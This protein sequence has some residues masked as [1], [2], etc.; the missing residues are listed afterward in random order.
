[1]L[2]TD[3]AQAHDF[4]PAC[5][6]A[7]AAP[8][9]CHGFSIAPLAATAL[10][11]TALTACAWQSTIYAPAGVSDRGYSERQIEGDRFRILD[12][13]RLS[14]APYAY[15]CC[16]PFKGRGAFVPQR[17]VFSAWVRCCQKKNGL[18][19]LARNRSVLRCVISSDT[20]KLRRRPILH[21]QPFSTSNVISTA[22]KISRRTDPPPW[23]N[24]VNLQ[25]ELGSNTVFPDRSVFV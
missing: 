14:S 16:L 4:F 15:L 9:V 24:G 25:P 20:S 17:G 21:P 11:A 23:P 6:H 19:G 13:S 5:A 22:A 7:E 18:S 12:L 2:R 10:T 8:G 1:M 3:T